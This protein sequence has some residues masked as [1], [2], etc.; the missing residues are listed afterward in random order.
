MDREGGIGE[1]RPA[2]PAL[3][4]ATRGPDLAVILDTIE[5]PTVVVGPDCRVVHFNRA[6]TTVLRLKP[7]DIGR[8]A[9]DALT[10]ISDLDNLCAQ[11]MS[12]QTQHRLEIREGDR[13]FLL[14]IAPCIGLDGPSGAVLT[15]TNITAFRASLDQAIY[16]REYTKAILNT[17][18]EP[19]VLLDRA[20]RVQTA[21]QAFYT[22]LRC[23]RDQV[24]NVALCDIGDGV[25]KTS[26][27][28]ESLRAIFE[29]DTELKSVEAELVFPVVGRRT[30]LVDARRLPMTGDATLLLAFRDIS[31]RKQ[32]EL[33]SN[34]L[35]SI[36]ESSDDAIVSKDLN[37]IIVSWNKGA[38]R[39]FGYTSA[40]AIGQ[41][42]AIVIPPD[43]LDEEPK[44][45]D[46][47]KRGE[48]VEHFETIRMRKDGSRLNIS[49]T[50]SPLRDAA[51]RILGASKIARDITGRIRQDEALKAANVALEQA[52]A[53][54]QQF[55][56]SASHD[57]QEPL[58]TIMIYSQLLQNTYG[59]SLGERGNEFVA[60]TVQAAAR[61]DNLLKNLRIYT[62]VS[63]SDEP[64]GE[65]EAAEALQKALLDLEV[66]IKESG[67]SISSALLPRVRMNDFQLE[68]V[69]QNIIGNAIRY[70][71]ELPPHVEISAERQEGA[72]LFTVRDN[73]IGIEPQFT[74]Q[75]FG[76]FKR[77]HSGAEYPGTGMGLAICKRII[78]RGGGRIWVESVPG[79]GSTFYF[80]I[81]CGTMAQE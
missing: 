77:L 81:P 59:D 16:E 33:N 28:W 5:L 31:D 42:I 74:E 1:A 61:L 4:D 3:G 65:S 41:S 60:H 50:I 38:E 66:A 8:S 23:S 78:E 20:L 2:L 64:A 24:Q 17:I 44:I 34:R 37:G 71:S 12:D 54:L 57:L 46:R 55:A 53:D 68:Q 75:V 45:L 26:D 32:L 36:I 6:A 29:Q 19:L 35:A 11:V 14:R 9:G 80:T 69:F 47:L 58:R 51:G 72:W 43:R 39:L 56:Y 52:N 25:W 13:L 76:M 40:E 70:R 48:R 49:L 73:G 15:F 22:M 27:L 62:R 10:G 67:A 7:E 63:Q 18:I 21:N 30:V 79:K